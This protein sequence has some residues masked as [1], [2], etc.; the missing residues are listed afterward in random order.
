MDRDAAGL[1]LHLAGRRVAR[2]GAVLDRDVAV[3]LQRHAPARLHVA[4]DGHRARLRRQSHVR[5]VVRDRRLARVDDRVVVD[6][7]RRLGDR[8][9]RLRR[10]QLRVVL[11]RERGAVGDCR[12]RLVG[13]HNRL[14]GE[15][16][17]AAG[18][19]RQLLASAQLAVVLHHDVA[20][21]RVE[22]DRAGRREL[23]LAL[24][25]DAVLREHRRVLRRA[26]RA[27]SAH[28]ARDH[29]G[30]PAN[31]VDHE[32]PVLRLEPERVSGGDAVALRPHIRRVEHLNV[33]CHGSGRDRLLRRH[34]PRVL[35][36]DVLS[37]VEHHRVVRANFILLRRSGRLA[38]LDVARRGR[39]LRQAAGLDRGGRLHRHVLC[40][41]S[42]QGAVSQDV[43]IVVNEDGAG[44]SLGGVEGQRI[45]RSEVRRILDRDAGCTVG[46]DSCHAGR[47]DRCIV[48]DAYVTSG[49]NRDVSRRVGIIDC[50]HRRG[51]ICRIPGNRAGLDKGGVNGGIASG[52]NRNRLGGCHLRAVLRREVARNRGGGGAGRA[53]KHLARHG[54]DLCVINCHIACARALGV[55]SHIV[56]R[57]Q[58][59]TRVDRN[60]TVGC[61]DGDV[62]LASG[63][64]RNRLAPDRLHKAVLD[65]DV[66]LRVV[67]RHVAVASDD[68]RL[69]L[70]NRGS[71]IRARKRDVISGC[72]GRDRHRLVGVNGRAVQ[73]R[74]GLAGCQL[75]IPVNRLER[76]GRLHNH[77]FFSVE[78]NLALRPDI[79]R[80][81]IGH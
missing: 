63:G 61:R 59:G 17:R 6:V 36:H 46:G 44:A 67:D 50:H 22:V 7:E 43:A 26:V 27:V 4:V 23:A 32:R 57:E 69:R 41:R 74:D 64:G 72:A 40:S 77:V 1:R 71:R 68:R 18:V 31:A 53:D 58:L 54:R 39:D 37:C 51:G 19:G 75:D 73:N 24:N 14:V 35:D 60:A 56:G 9:D 8:R 15:A 25:R 55:D 45:L 20:G 33:I 28:D 21:R 70:G 34:N 12:D 80:R 3:R 47:A 49:S 81:R 65:R 29:V 79:R 16:D 52:Q 78:R 10:N 38:H 42:R 66:A 13:R 48:L 30:V 2:A 11:D 5:V 76:G 62:G